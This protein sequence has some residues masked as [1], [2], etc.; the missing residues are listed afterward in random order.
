MSIGALTGICIALFVAAAAFFRL[1]GRPTTGTPVGRV[2]RWLAFAGT[3]G[4]TVAALPLALSDSA[5]VLLLLAVPLVP[6][7]LVVV[8]DAT[9]RLVGTTTAAAALLMLLW[10]VFLAS[11]LTPYFVFPALL[12]G[13]AALASIRPRAAGRPAGAA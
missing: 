1:R 3:V 8:S 10:G 2:L 12:L 4:T 5:V 11:F 9:G 6:A 13:A 7:A